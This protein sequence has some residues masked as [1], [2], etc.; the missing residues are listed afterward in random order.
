NSKYTQSAAGATSV[1]KCYLTLTA[2]QQVASAGAGASNCSAGKYC[3]STGTI[4]YNTDGGT[5]TYTGTAC[6]TGSYSSTGSSTCTACPVGT[7]TSGTG[8]AFNT[9]AATTCAT[10]CS[11]SANVRSGSDGWETP[12]WSANTV[13]NLCTI[14]SSGCAAN[15]YKNSN[16]CSTCSSGTSNKYTKSTAGTTTVNN[17]YLT[18]TAGNYVASAG[19]GAVT[20]AAGGYCTSTANIYYGG[21]HSDSHPTT[22]GRTACGKGTYNANTGSTSSSACTSCGDGT[23]NPNTGSTASSACLA[24]SSLKSE[25]TKSDSGRDATTDCYL[26]TSA[27]KYVATANENQVTC[28]ANGYC[29][30]SVKVYYGSTGGRTACTSPYSS[31]STGQ[32]D[33]NDCYLTTTAGNYVATAGAG[34]VT[35]AAGGYCAGGSTIYKGGSVSGR[36]T[37]GGRTACAAG[38][39]NANT[40][41][42]A[43]SACASCTGF[44]YA[45][46]TGNTSCSACP[47]AA[48]HKQTTFNSALYDGNSVTSTNAVSKTGATAITQCEVQ[49]WLSGTRGKANEHATYN[50]SSQKYDVYVWHKW[51]DAHAGYYLTSKDSCGS[52]AYYQ[53]AKQCP[54]G[55][56]CPGK[57]RVECN[58]SNEST[59][60]TTNFGLNSCPNAYPNS[61]TGTTTINNCYLTLV[62][63]KYVSAAKA[64]ASACPGGKYSTSTANIYYDGSGHTTTST[65]SDINAGYFCAGGAKTATPSSSSDSVSG[66]ACGGCSGRNSFSGAGASSCSTVS[67]GYY[68]TGCNGSNNLCTGQSQC[69]AGYYCASGVRNTCAGGKYS[70]T[71][72]ATSCSNITAGYFCAGGAKTATPTSTSDSVSGAA[73]GQCTSDS[74][75]GRPTYTESTG[76]AASCSVCPAVASSSAYASRVKSYSGW[77][78]S[79]NTGPHNSVTGCITNFYD[80]DDDGNYN[81]YCHYDTTSSDYT[82]CYT[83]RATACAAGKYDT[84]ESTPEWVGGNTQA[85]NCTGVDC[86]KG[87]VCTNTTAGY[88]SPADALTQTACVTGSYSSAGASSCTACP[89]GKTTSGT[90]TAFNTDAN[91]T[92][93]TSCSSIANLKA[94]AT[95]SWNSSNN[96]M[97]NLCSVGTCLAGSYKSSNTCPICATDKYSADGATSCTSCLT[98]YH[99]TGTARTDHDASS[100]CK[101][102]CSGG[103]YL[104]TANDTSCTAVGAGKYAAASSIAHGSTGSATSCS[105]G[106]TTIGYGPGA[107]EAGDCGRILHTGDGKLY[108]RSTKKTT[109]TF[110]VKVGD[111]TFYGNMSTTEKNMSDGVSKKLKVKDNGTTYWVHDDSVN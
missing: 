15:S 55:S 43:S 16:A 63:G 94:W 9:D 23:Y 74:T 34:Q 89:G 52:Y 7:T 87:K 97:S 79:G 31:A 8:T 73:C 30:G 68:S 54:A 5:A 25:Y 27:T 77:W 106:L 110:N 37:T 45:A 60:H 78:G 76:G 105:T 71:S 2:G 49:N 19:G 46:G 111:T 100:D 22:G 96:T 42:S 70:S 48:D 26:N 62:A 65:C 69:T 17:C 11:N 107:D 44:T 72:G 14:K 50:T 18:L 109:K 12:S 33:A 20:C 29:P 92:C 104:K 57:E 81:I 98:N 58:S 82:R 64:G 80:N 102:S 28:A 90:G 83:Q 32:D 39:A 56:Y 103:Y 51:T 3:T 10:T 91:T 1:G 67:S 40:G 38:T 24:C 13:S 86:M 47:T 41:S 6:T 108:L 21:T 88:Y 99:I 75:T 59:V 93:A 95:P 85:A 101:I 4:Y 61:A 35:C 84:L 66:A 53:D 36:S